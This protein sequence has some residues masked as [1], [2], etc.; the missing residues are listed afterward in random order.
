MPLP[1]SAGDM[2]RIRRLERV[3]K[4]VP[5]LTPFVYS[6]SSVNTNPTSTFVLACIDPR[7]AYAL[8]KFLDETYAQS[9][10]SYDL[11]ILAGAAMG[12]RLTGNNVAPLG[13]N[14]VP[15]CGIVS[16]TNSWQQTLFDHM[17]VAITLHNVTNLVIIDHL[18]C[19]AYSACAGE[20]PDINYTAHS[21]QYTALLA[22]INARNFVSNAGTAS[23][24]GSAIFTTA[25]G[26]FFD[27]TRTSSITNLR[28]YT[29]NV[30]ITEP[31][32]TNAGARVL[33]L[34][35]IDPRYASVLTSFLINYKDV[36]FMY[37]LFITAGASIG[38]NQSYVGGDVTNKRAAGVRGSYANNILADGAA[39][40]GNLG[41]NWGPTFFDHLSVARALHGITEVWAFDH[42]DCGAY[43][44]ILYGDLNAP[45]LNRNEHIT[46]LRKL[47][48]MITNYA[49]SNDP[50]NGSYQLSFKGF[51]INT[52]GV[53][54]N[55][56]R[57]GAGVELEADYNFGS[58]RIR[59]PASTF[60][61]SVA[62][63]RTDYLTN[64]QPLQTDGGKL[65]G[66][67]LS[68]VNKTTLC[69]CETEKHLPRVG[70]LRSAVYQHSRLI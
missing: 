20:T 5:R 19:G 66:T 33:V 35:C 7:F 16:A 32:G 68:L 31:K 24:L 61:D 49:A 50:L 6:S 1:L 11:F 69:D 65:N 18:D 56:V 43:K 59:N 63:S 36:Q 3:T 4:V 58:S 52:S 45:D 28:D 27:G 21:S 10:Q 46:E 57:E 30:L 60:T 25:A 13:G 14:T 17:Q 2:T 64:T 48:S 37:D 54:T 23:T 34:G 70:I 15:T 62:Y 47:E 41:R 22:I 12:G 38:V 55:V 29:N 44:A 9:G 67:A 53:I 8:E 40:I 26:Y 51:I 39:G 42:L